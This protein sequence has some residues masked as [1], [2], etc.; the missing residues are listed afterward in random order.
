MNGVIDQTKPATDLDSSL[1]PPRKAPLDILARNDMQREEEPQVPSG[2]H[3]LA[4]VLKQRPTDLAP[5]PEISNALLPPIV[6]EKIETE[7][8]E[9]F[10]VDSRVLEF[11][12]RLVASESDPVTAK[13][14]RRY[15]WELEYANSKERVREILNEA[16]DIG[17][18]SPEQYAM[19][20]SYLE[21]PEPIIERTDDVKNLIEAEGGPDVVASDFKDLYE[22]LG[23]LGVYKDSGI[24]YS[25]D[26]LIKAIEEIRKSENPLQNIVNVPRARGLRKLVA[27]LLRH[28][29]ILDENMTGEKVFVVPEKLI[30]Y[31]EGLNKVDIGAKLVLDTLKQGGIT[32]QEVLKILFDY[33]RPGL[34]F[35]EE[36]HKEILSI[37]GESEEGVSVVLDSGVLEQN[38]EKVLEQ[39]RLEY[40]RAMADYDKRKSNTQKFIGLLGNL[41]SSDRIS[42]SDAVENARRLELEAKERIGQT[43][44]AYIEAKITK[45]EKDT[46]SIGDEFEKLSRRLENADAEWNILQEQIRES[47]PKN[48]RTEWVKERAS[49]ALKV[50]S[51]VPI[52]ARLAFV[53]ILIGTGAGVAGGLAF[54]AS[55]AGTRIVRGAAGALGS[56]YFG[57]R[58]GKKTERENEE[59]RKEY[60]A[61]YISRDPSVTSEQKEKKYMEARELE[62][63]RMKG[64]RVKKAM[65]MV[66]AGAGTGI[67][68][69]LTQSLLETPLLASTGGGLGG[70][71]IMDRPRVEGTKSFDGIARPKAVV[72]PVSAKV[73]PPET[74][75]VPKPQIPEGPK[76]VDV[77]QVR[78]EASSQGGWQTILD[79]KAAV[80][81]KYGD[82][83][84]QEIKTN[85]M[86]KPSVEIAKEYGFY[87]PGDTGGD[88]AMM[89]KGEH[90]GVDNHGHLVYERGG[91]SID[92]VD[93]KTGK[94]VTFEETGGEMFTPKVNESQAVMPKAT[95][96]VPDVPDVSEAEITKVEMPPEPEVIPV[97][98]PLESRDVF[99]VKKTTPSAV[100]VSQIRVPFKETFVD[101]LDRNGVKTMEIEGLKIAQERPFGSGKILVLDDKFQNGI[102]NRSIREAF[103][104]AFDKNEWFSGYKEMKGVVF[105]GGRLSVLH[106]VEEDPNIVR[107]L[108]N[109]KEIAKG[110]ITEN[111]SNIK[112]DS[113]L[114][115]GLFGFLV[116]T[117]Y[118]KALKF[119]ELKDVIKSFE[120][121]KK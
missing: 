116:E 56:T 37:L 112:L 108:L 118:E 33:S 98:Q 53:P 58:Y 90:L 82:H 110:W 35:T 14:F 25:P 2:V 38:P 88:S 104:E 73:V 13:S 85:F 17:N 74:P 32:K 28:E 84:P 29:I 26:G 11:F 46:E 119:K 86:D 105:D 55:I 44:D 21:K 80:I 57:K 99:A 107:V 117:P 120:F 111:G 97:V 34:A 6:P 91:K 60:E 49:R 22:K 109:G 12:T 20:L 41:V 114:K 30:L 5:E 10:R 54:G 43:L 76:V 36:E 50:W 63:R 65:I 7:P 70:S 93:T 8:K 77:S 48:E 39:A 52:T 45:V 115:G 113:N 67:L 42:M 121:V 89:F 75:A 106:G 83:I 4:D 24:S 51:K 96:D 71:Q 15:Q 61:T 19:V 16:R 40:I 66:G 101:I 31:I 47:L 92:M 79:L 94:V 78:V 59:I 103:L 18:I 87:K 81:R 72:S 27:E 100:E 102:E 68:A 23:H 95:S 64:Q 69:G 3:D 9:S 1:T 62:K